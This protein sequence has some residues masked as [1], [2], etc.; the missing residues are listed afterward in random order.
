MYM[1]RRHRADLETYLV[2]WKKKG[3][4]LNK[5]YR[6]SGAVIPNM[7]KVIITMG[8]LPAST[9]ASIRLALKGITSH[10]GFKDTLWDKIRFFEEH[11]GSSGHANILQDL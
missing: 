2:I 9:N 5:F 3:G 7:T 1:D 10:A 4:Y 6:L 8:T 11:R